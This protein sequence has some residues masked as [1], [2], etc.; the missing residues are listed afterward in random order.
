MAVDF[1]DSDLDTILDALDEM[2]RKDAE[3]L[4]SI[5]KLLKILPEP[6]D[7]E[8]HR[9]YG[10]FR[11]D[12]AK[13]EKKLKQEKKIRR[14]KITLLKAKIIMLQQERAIDRLG[15]PDPEESEKN[16]DHP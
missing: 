11:K 4:P 16:S 6:S 15:D 13:Q 3:Y 1:T 14:E 12:M 10:E 9:A 2:E 7:P 5:E 8:L